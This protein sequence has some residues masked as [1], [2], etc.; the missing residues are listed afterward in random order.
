[1]AANR[2]L[3]FVITMLAI[4]IVPV[5]FVTTFVLGILVTCSFGFLLLPLSLVWMVLIAPLIGVSWLCT[6]AEGLRGIFGLFGI[7]WAVVTHIYACLVPSMGELESRADKLMLV[8]SWPF[9]W[10]YWLFSLDKL[11][12]RSSEGDVLR[13]VLDRISRGDTLKQRTV[14]RLMVGEELDPN[15]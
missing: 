13:D 2:I 15:V 11:D 8:E 10:E 1:M 9:S 14:S 5:Q 7:P 6:K 12:L 4:I 3:D